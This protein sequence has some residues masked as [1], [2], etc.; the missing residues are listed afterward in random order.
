MRNKFKKDYK[1]QRHSK[2][3]S[4]SLVDILDLLNKCS[5]LL[6][7]CEC[8]SNKKDKPHYEDID[9]HKGEEILDDLLAEE[10]T[11]TK[12]VNEVTKGHDIIDVTLPEVHKCN[13][14]KCSCKKDERRN[15]THIIDLNFELNRI[16]NYIYSD[17]DTYSGEG[18]LEYNLIR[19][20][21][22]E[23]VSYLSLELL[24]DRLTEVLSDQGYDVEEDIF[25]TQD[26]KR[27]FILTIE[28]DVE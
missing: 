12:W 19:D 23:K 14:H 18:V 15:S 6:N 10:D 4:I 3:D 2:D 16:L 9:E 7:D 27:K 26:D 22:F 24:L 21:G 13:C 8:A 25:E 11:D 28:W 17:I 5:D 20:F 1:N